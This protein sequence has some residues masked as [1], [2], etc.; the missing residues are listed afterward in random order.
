MHLIVHNNNLELCQYFLEKKAN[1]NI[2]NVFLVILIILLNNLWISSYFN[3]IPLHE[4]AQ[5]K[6]NAIGELLINNGS[7]IEIG[8]I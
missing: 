4:A 2:A 3:Q 6:S 7:H 1:V 5:L 8:D